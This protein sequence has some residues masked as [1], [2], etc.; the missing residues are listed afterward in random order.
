[1]AAKHFLDRTP[2][3]KKSKKK[4]KTVKVKKTNDNY[5]SYNNFASFIDEDV[6]GGSGIGYHQN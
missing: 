1:L 3:K 4:T 5:E 6:H 2:Y